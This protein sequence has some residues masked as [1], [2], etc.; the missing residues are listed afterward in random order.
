MAM[1]VMI[2][3]VKIKGFLFADKCKRN[4]T[5]D[6]L[7]NWLSDWLSDWLVRAKFCVQCKQSEDRR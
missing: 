4:P 5:G 6:W 2:K 1:I 3:V 7:S